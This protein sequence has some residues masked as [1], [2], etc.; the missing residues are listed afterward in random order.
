MEKKHIIFYSITKV[1]DRFDLYDIQVYV[2]S[3]RLFKIVYIECM[4]YGLLVVAHGECS[5]THTTLV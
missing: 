5:C 1:N 3:G 4:C 2:K